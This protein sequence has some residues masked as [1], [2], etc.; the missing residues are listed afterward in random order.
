MIR[1][2]LACLRWAAERVGYW[3]RPYDMIADARRWFWQRR[4]RCGWSLGLR[5]EDDGDG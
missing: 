2:W 3:I 5:V 4:A 1:Y